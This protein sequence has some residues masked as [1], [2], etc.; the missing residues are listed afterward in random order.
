MAVEDKRLL[1]Y[2]L[3]LPENRAELFNGTELQQIYTLALAAGQSG[4][5]NKA[6][7]K[8]VETIVHKLDRVLPY[9]PD[10]EEN[11][12]ELEKAMEV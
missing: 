1:E 3:A 8:T 2:L 4:E 11:V 7:L 9:L 12:Q 10:A 5:M 6:A